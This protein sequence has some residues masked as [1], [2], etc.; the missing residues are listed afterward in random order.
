MT[1]VTVRVPLTVTTGAAGEEE[2]ELFVSWLGHVIERGGLPASL[3][4]EAANDALVAELVRA[5]RREAAAASVAEL[6]QLR[7]R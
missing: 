7:R 2:L 3:T 6:F 5:W 1:R 4:L